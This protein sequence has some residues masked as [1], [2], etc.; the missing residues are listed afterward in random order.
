MTTRRYDIDWIRVI[1]IW[2]L[3]FYHIAIG[4][5]PW[6]T[7]IG[8]IRHETPLDALEIFMSILGVWRIPLLFF[9]SGMGVCFA[10][11]KRSWLA[12]LKE[13]AQ[14]ILLPFVFG[15]L[16]IVPM[17]IWLWRDYYHQDQVYVPNPAH[18]WFLGNILIYVVLFTP[19]FLYLR[20]QQDK[21]VGRFIKKVMSHPAGFILLILPF[22]LEA[23]WVNPEMFTLYATTVHGFLL[24]LIA[25]LLGYLMVYA[26]SSFWEL[27]GRWKWALLLAAVS[28]FGL[29]LGY[30]ELAAPNA[31]L[32]VESNL[33]VLAILGL[34]YRY[35][36]RP[37]PALSYLSQAAYPVYILH[38][39]F[40]Y[41]ASYFLFPSGISAWWAFALVLVLTL[42]G[43]YATYELIR[44]IKWLRPLFGLKI[45]NRQETKSFNSTLKQTQS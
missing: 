32:A 40:L 9:V 45:T 7:L 23:V 22:V 21:A 35:L 28:L 18:L 39:L 38:M 16:T 19:L 25:F 1:A 6:G 34:G 8:F 31:L 42:V 43:C 10:M 30:Y 4:F 17:H 13:R 44:R 24:G 33:W 20:R 3:L 26:G 29:R 5:R 14:R 2:L 37:H 27:L 41:L 12:L 36:N 15:S 11:R